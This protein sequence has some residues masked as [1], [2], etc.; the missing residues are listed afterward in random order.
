MV[1]NRLY[2][3]NFLI[4]LKKRITH[5]GVTQELSKNEQISVTDFC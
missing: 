1:S 3:S 5:K 2:I 4:K